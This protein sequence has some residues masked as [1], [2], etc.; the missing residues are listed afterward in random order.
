MVADVLGPQEVR[1]EQ[2]LLELALLC[3]ATFGQGEVEQPVGVDGV[4]VDVLEEPHRET[5]T[6]TEVDQLPLGL[7]HLGLGAAVATRDHAGGELV[8]VARRGGSSSKER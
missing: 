1:R 5:L 6:G 3:G 4:G 8:A 2:C 7:A